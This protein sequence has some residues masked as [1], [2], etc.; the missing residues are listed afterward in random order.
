[1]L[2][3]ATGVLVTVHP[4]LTDIAS[5]AMFLN[6]FSHFVFLIEKAGRSVILIF[7]Q[8]FGDEGR[9]APRLRAGGSRTIA[10]RIRD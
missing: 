8:T 10:E 5:T 6:I 7:Y 1:V 4:Q 3:A 2:E 9:P